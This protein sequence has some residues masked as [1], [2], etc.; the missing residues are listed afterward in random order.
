MFCV[1][2]AILVA[3]LLSF[4]IVVNVVCLFP[5]PCELSYQVSVEVHVKDLGVVHAL[6]EVS[7]VCVCLCC[8]IGRVSLCAV[9]MAVWTIE[10]TDLFHQ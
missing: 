2:A 6:C 10:L 8:V 7:C 5:K 9:G 1:C 4:L 3:F